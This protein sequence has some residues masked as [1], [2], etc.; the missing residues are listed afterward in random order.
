MIQRDFQTDERL[1]EKLVALYNEEQITTQDAFTLR[2]LSLQCVVRVYIEA[3]RSGLTAIFLD[4]SR[5]IV[6]QRYQQHQASSSTRGCITTVSRPLLPN[7][8]ILQHPLSQQRAD[9]LN[10]VP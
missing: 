2:D 10:L 8:G 1:F 9:Q 3:I 7:P 4:Q 5:E 6:H